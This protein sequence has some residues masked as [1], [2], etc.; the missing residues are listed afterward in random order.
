[1]RTA[2]P[3]LFHQALF[4]PG[5]CSWFWWNYSC[6]Q[7][8]KNKS[9]VNSRILRW[10][11]YYRVCSV[12]LIIYLM[13]YL[14]HFSLFTGKANWTQRLAKSWILFCNLVFFKFH[15][16]V[17]LYFQLLCLHLLLSSQ[18]ANAML[19]PGGTVDSL[20]PCLHCPATS[21]EWKTS[22]RKKVLGKRR[23]AYETSRLW[24]DR[25][26]KEEE[27]LNRSVFEE[28][29]EKMKKPIK[30]MLEVIEE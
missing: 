29:R 27:R 24:T 17:I 2:E 18:S 19:L 3:F 5:C 20:W 1:M 25:L 22:G 10:Y 30:S 13:A 26:E 4:F 7:L 6:L 12:W 23:K 15:G 14:A 28:K 21:Y 16:H 8:F 11:C 9:V